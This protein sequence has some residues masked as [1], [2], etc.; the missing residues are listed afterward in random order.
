M[1][2]LLAS[3]PEG[4]LREAHAFWCG[5][6]RGIPGS[7]DGIVEALAAA[8]ADPRIVAARLAALGKKLSA[9]LAQFLA[10]PGFT[11]TERELRRAPPF[12]RMGAV[13]VEA[14]VGALERRGF[15]VPALVRGWRD[16]GESGYAVPVP[17][18]EAVLEVRLRES[19]G[20]ADL[21]TL[22]G[23][24]RRL[25]PPEKPRAGKGRG[26]PGGGRARGTLAEEGDVAA[27][28]ERLPEALRRL[29]RETA[30]RAGGILPRSLFQRFD[31]GLERFDAAAWKRE[32]DRASL[33]TVLDL[34]LS[35]Y[36]IGLAEPTLLVFPEVV[37]ALLRR[38][39]RDEPPTVEAE[40][41]CG[42]DLASNLSRLLASLV[43]GRV[44]FTAQGSVFRTTERRLAAGLIPMRTREAEAE[45]V[46]ETLL[47]FSLARRLVD[48]TGER[49]LAL[50]TAGAAFG[51][52]PLAEKVRRILDWSLEERGLP[53]EVLHQSRL[54]RLFL[55]LLRRL[56]PGRWVDA[57]ALPFVARNAYLTRL[58]R[59]G[60][61]DLIS[62]RS[63]H[64]VP[65]ALEDPQRLAWN[66]FA[67]VRRRAH[68]LG[69][70]DLGYD[71]G[72]RPVALR[73]AP[74][75]ARLLGPLRPGGSGASLL[76]NPDFEV[77]LFP[78]AGDP[79]DLVHALDRFC[80]R[81]HSDPVFRFRITEASVRLGLA[82]GMSVAS[83]LE[84]L[85]GASAVPLPQNVR[86]SLRAWAGRAGVVRMET[87][88][89]VRSEEAGVLD[90]FLEDP[91]VRNRLI[92]R[93]SPTTALLRESPDARGVRS[94]A[95]NLGL[96][97]EPA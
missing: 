65:A 75:G 38:R 93:I 78:G 11:R 24:L 15:L 68:L 52:L 35:R 17:L 64:P 21:L 94:R 20:V 91:H 44:R 2:P 92:E 31:L 57:M 30:V 66:L 51:A 13:E 12:E 97:L 70:V 9:L 76:V 62:S 32:L 27:R 73:L 59:L 85:K 18:G 69:L 90:R 88:T 86:F 53:G 6:G 22:R 79:H 37:L 47:R 33:G 63:P 54:R 42:A 46:F 95:R 29:V 34:D 61:A 84:T 40:A 55:R 43:E 39:A 49:T 87:V 72:G 80:E 41:V 1:A 16:F 7:R 83:M 89:L 8:M 82:E 3:L 81:T 71:G 14:A 58:D 45:E 4:A 74:F 77:V 67:W 19:C 25:R 50:S 26:E 23:H 5:E 10:A 96:R 56:A 60:V 48:R 28:I 36:G